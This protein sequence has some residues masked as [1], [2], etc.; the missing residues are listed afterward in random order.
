MTDEFALQVDDQLRKLCKITERE[1][2][3]VLEEVRSCARQ[4]VGGDMWTELELLTLEFAQR[5]HELD[6]Y[7][8]LLRPA[9][10]IVGATR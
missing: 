8:A 3:R 9:P 7:R 6:K 10:T 5:R 1:C 2:E 4:S